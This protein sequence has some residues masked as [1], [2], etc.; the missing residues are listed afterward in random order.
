M[1]RCRCW[2]PITRKPKHMRLRKDGYKRCNKCG[3]EVPGLGLRAKWGRERM[4]RE[5][6]AELPMISQPPAQAAP[7]VSRRLRVTWKSTE[8]SQP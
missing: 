3:T 5:G 7:A 1:T 8:A 4:A 6:W 2:N